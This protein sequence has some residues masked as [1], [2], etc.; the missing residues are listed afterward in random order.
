[1]FVTKFIS[2]SLQLLN[3]GN[4]NSV[5]N[6]NY[7]ENK[8]A[9]ELANHD[10]TKAT[11]YNQKSNSSNQNTNIAPTMQVIDYTSRLETETNVVYVGLSDIPPTDNDI[12]EVTNDTFEQGYNSNDSK[13]NDNSNCVGENVSNRLVIR[14]SKAVKPTRHMVLQSTTMGMTE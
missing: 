9:F 6:N 2:S 1:M 12:N 14:D 4:Q 7:F 11:L 3:I 13:H 8:Q 5:G 10:K